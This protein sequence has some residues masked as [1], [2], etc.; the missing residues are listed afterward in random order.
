MTLLTVRYLWISKNIS[1]LY[2]NKK[3]AGNTEPNYIVP[4]FIGSALCNALRL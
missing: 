3:G 4:A 2:N 1:D